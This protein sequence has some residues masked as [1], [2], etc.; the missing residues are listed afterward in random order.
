MQKLFSEP[1]LKNAPC[2]ATSV[3]PLPGK[4]EELF[5]G[6]FEREISRSLNNYTG[7]FPHNCLHCNSKIVNWL[8]FRNNPE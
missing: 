1:F 4:R 3:S 8:P 7:S 6:S 5:P 2:N